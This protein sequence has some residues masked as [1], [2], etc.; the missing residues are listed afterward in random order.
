[1]TITK[2]K[3]I[4]DA[5]NRIE[6]ITNSIRLEHSNKLERLDEHL[7]NMNGTLGENCTKIS[8]HEIIL[9]QLKGSY[10]FVKVVGL[11]LTIILAILTVN[12][13]IPR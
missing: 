2:S 10:A 7:K 9:Q 11:V 1:M 4:V 12:T 8:E 3:E 6:D 5:L 13:F